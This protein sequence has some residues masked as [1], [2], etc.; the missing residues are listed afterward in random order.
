MRKRTWHSPYAS[1]ALYTWTR[2]SA[3]RKSTSEGSGLFGTAAG[4]YRPAHLLRLKRRAA[5]FAAR[6][7]AWR[8]DARLATRLLLRL[9][10]LERVGDHRL[11]GHG[12]VSGGLAAREL[13]R[14][15]AAGAHDARAHELLGSQ[16]C[17]VARAL[18]QQGL[19]R[20]LLKSACA[21]LGP[22]LSCFLSHLLSSSRLYNMHQ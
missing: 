22:S 12:E 1:E 4:P 17:E 21:E 3:Q 20:H 13:V 11:A 10:L 16:P 8:S 14:E 15:G 5:P 2:K 7:S 9:L 19:K 18:P 6:C